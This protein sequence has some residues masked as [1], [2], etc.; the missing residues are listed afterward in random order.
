M[1]AIIGAGISGLSCAY[2]LKSYGEDVL[3]Y[4]AGNSLGTGASGNKEAL[5]NP[6]ISNTQRS[7]EMEKISK[8]AVDLYRGFGFSLNGSLHLPTSEKVKRLKKTHPELFISGKEASELAGLDI[9]YESVLFYKQG[10]SVDT[11]KILE[12]LA[13]GIRIQFNS[14]VDFNN[15][16][17]NVKII[18][19]AS[20]C[21]KLPL[22]LVRG[23]VSFIEPL[24]IKIPIAYGGYLLPSGVVGSSFDHGVINNELIMQSYILTRLNDALNV[25]FSPIGGRVSYRLNTPDRLPLI[26]EISKNI[27]VSLG[28]GSRGFQT[29]LV[30]GKMLADFLVKGTPIPAS[31][32]V[33]RYV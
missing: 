16:K 1:I 20:P 7:K 4:E 3:V 17:A 29:G 31:L 23:E 12:K 2:F 22:E 14:K 8:E 27:L 19:T 32:D 15:I 28:H 21:F 26:G 24:D 30:A 6:V 18:C 25:K 11:K 9:P 10:G 5:I 13:D 33:K